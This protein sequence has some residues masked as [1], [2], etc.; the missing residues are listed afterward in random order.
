MADDA[1]MNPFGQTPEPSDAEDLRESLGAAFRVPRG[2]ESLASRYEAPKV[3]PI[4]ETMRVDEIVETLCKSLDAAKQSG[5]VAEEALKVGRQSR[6]IAIAALVVAA[7]SLV[8]MGLSLALQL[9]NAL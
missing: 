8:V 7:L 6:N 3:D 1:S 2:L 9:V 5:K 4:S